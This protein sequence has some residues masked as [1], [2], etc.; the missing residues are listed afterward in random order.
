MAS[1]EPCEEFNFTHAGGP[2]HLHPRLELRQ[3]IAAVPVAFE[4]SLDD[5][6]TEAAAASTPSATC[7]GVLA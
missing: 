3:A 6:E 7:A 4:E 1:L 5:F 2:L